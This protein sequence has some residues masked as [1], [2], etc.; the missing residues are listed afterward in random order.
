M[1][2]DDLRKFWSGF[3]DD[4]RFFSY[5]RCSDCGVLFNPSFFTDPQLQELYSDLA[6]NMEEQTG[7][8]AIS[9]TQ[10][11]YF[12]DAVRQKAPLTGDYLEIG[13][14]V[15]HVTRLAAEHGAFD[16][17]W[18]FE[19]NTAVHGALSAATLGKPHT[20]STV[21]TDLSSVP[22]GSVGMA[23]MIHVLD[24]MV[25]PLAMLEQVR[26]KLH[27]DGALVTVTHNEK[28][29]LRYAM[30][31]RWPPFCLQHPEV[32]NPASIRALMQRA[33]FGQVFV[34]R[35]K[36]YFPL[37][38]LAQQGLRVVGLKLDRVPLPRIS[39]GLRL[40]NIMTTARL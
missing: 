17:F 1:D 9:A 25:D 20:I 10:R 35:S 6:P 13:P 5:H 15:G 23:V 4:K 11:G 3:H 34:Q 27:P 28:S 18:L 21:M 26:R 31:L 22:D 40:G 30:G 7:I 36:N 24:H 14:D 32:Y 8:S 12:D 33:G 16:R 29:A 2:F 37:D 19:P 39:V 38:F